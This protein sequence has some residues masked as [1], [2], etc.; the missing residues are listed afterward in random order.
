MILDQIIK[1]YNAATRG[2]TLFGPITAPSLIQSLIQTLT[3]V[4]G[5]PVAWDVSAGA[6][7]VVAITDNVAYTIANPT[8]L[9]VGQQVAITIQNTS[10]APNGAGAW[11]TLYKNSTAGVIPAIATGFNRTFTFYYNGVNL[12]EVTDAADV[13]N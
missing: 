9:A 6:V 11:D 7:A 12:I 1:F 2:I 5:T 4:S 8:N 10:G 13:A 3:Y